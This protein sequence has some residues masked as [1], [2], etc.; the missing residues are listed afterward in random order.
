MAK[1]RC[2]GAKLIRL[3]TQL[4]MTQEKLAAMS[5]ASI[6]TVQRAE[7][8]GQLQIE[9]AASL[10]AALKIT[11]PELSVADATVASSLG[12][13]EGDSNAVVL[14]PI[15]SGKALLEIVYDSFSG[16]L[17]CE[18]EPTAENIDALT[19]MVDEIE[20]LIPNPWADPEPGLTLSQRLRHAVT[21][22]SKLTLLQDI[23]VAVFA[24]TYTARAQVPRYDS[25]EGHMYIKGRF[26]FEAVTICRVM[27][28]P[29]QAGRVVIKV[30]DKW[31]ALAPSAVETN[32]QED[33]IPF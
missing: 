3:R 13:D 20:G 33:D 29:R 24:G 21:L 25:D 30:N 12:A 11:L 8:G 17:Y 18:V 9:T 5:N 26:P 6:R 28:A 19:S 15:D 4:A 10:A 16:K 2:D 1:V 22:T 7:R 23:G 27:L 31:T 32:E 14:R